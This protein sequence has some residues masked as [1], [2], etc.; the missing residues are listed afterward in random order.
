MSC[1]TES[2]ELQCI[3]NEMFVITWRDTEYHLDVCRATNGAHIEIFQRI[4]NFVRY[5]FRKYLHFP[6]NSMVEDL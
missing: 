2:T 6:I 1:L 3:T 4:R 5:S